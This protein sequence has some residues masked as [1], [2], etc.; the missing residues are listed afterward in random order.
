MAGCFVV[1]RVVLCWFGDLVC[2]GL[3]VNL[4]FVFAFVIVGISYVIGLWLLVF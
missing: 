1:G 4:V 3:L 2:F